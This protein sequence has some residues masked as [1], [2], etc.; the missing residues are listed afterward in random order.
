M[1][2]TTAPPPQKRINSRAMPPKAST[3]GRAEPLARRGGLGKMIAHCSGSRSRG[4]SRKREK[5]I[6]TGMGGLHILF[7]DNHCLAVAK[8]APLLTQAPPG[9]PSLEALVRVYIKER[10]HKPGH[11]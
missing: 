4:A 2:M 3:Q 11:V 1:A 6:T 10:D 7:E 5:R 9:V 8:P